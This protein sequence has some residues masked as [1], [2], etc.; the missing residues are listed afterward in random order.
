[1][2]GALRIMKIQKSATA[3]TMESS[4]VYV[5]IGPCDNGINIE[6]ESVVEKQFGSKIKEVV[7]DVLSQTGVQSANVHIVDRGAL[8]CVIRARVETAIMRGKGEQ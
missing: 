5:E 3:G 4:D 7:C 1:M 2:K 6:L 8:E